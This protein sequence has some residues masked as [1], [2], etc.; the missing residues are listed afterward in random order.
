MY[1]CVRKSVSVQQGTP[2]ETWFT[3]NYPNYTRTQNVPLLP[4]ER[5]R[6]LTSGEM[7]TAIFAKFEVEA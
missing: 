6:M 3:S 4:E 7:D 1:A 2:L 5:A